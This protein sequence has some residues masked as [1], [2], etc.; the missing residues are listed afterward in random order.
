MLASR[1]VLASG[2]ATPAAPAF[3]LAL[4]RAKA[5]GVAFALKIA[6]VFNSLVLVLLLLPRIPDL[7]VLDLGGAEEGRNG[8]RRKTTYVSC[9]SVSPLFLDRHGIELTGEPQRAG[10]PDYLG[11]AERLWQFGDRCHLWRRRKIT[12]EHWKKNLNRREIMDDI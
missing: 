10:D 4:A 1:L 7:V 6:L 2:L 12:I 5:L 3:R 11:H 9:G 8:N